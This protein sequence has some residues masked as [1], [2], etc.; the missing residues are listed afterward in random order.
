MAGNSIWTEGE[1]VDFIKTEIRKSKRMFPYIDDNDKTPSWD[2][3]IFLYSNSSGEKSNLL[4]KIPVQV[5]GH[6]IKSFPKGNMKYRAEMADLRN[7]YNDKGVLYFVVC[8]RELEEGGFEK[9]GYYA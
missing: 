5:K 2:G 6:N 9:K 3:N 1:A 4:G 8:L 7:F